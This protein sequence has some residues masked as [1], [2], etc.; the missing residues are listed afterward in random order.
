MKQ[1]LTFVLIVLLLASL[2]PAA[3]LA[4]TPT[5]TPGAYVTL[6]GKVTDTGGNPLYGIYL[7]V[8]QQNG[9]TSAMLWTN[10]TGDYSTQVRTSATDRYTVLVNPLTDNDVQMFT[11]IHAKKQIVVVLY[12][13]HRPLIGALT[14]RQHLPIHLRTF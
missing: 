12:F 11:D 14:T 9:A 2:I 4:V 7:M 13:Q 3:S 8:Y 6:A 1:T 10:A 5:P